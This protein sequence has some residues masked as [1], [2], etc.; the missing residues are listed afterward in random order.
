MKTTN[1]FG[2][3]E[4]YEVNKKKKNNRK[5]YNLTKKINNQRPNHPT[6]LYLLTDKVLEW[7]QVLRGIILYLPWKK[8]TIIKPTWKEETKNVSECIVVQ[9][10]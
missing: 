5:N 7:N 3:F 6:C 10:Q 4:Y 9:N 2:S 8:K 1:V